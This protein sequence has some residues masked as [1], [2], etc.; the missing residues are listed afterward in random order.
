[1][2]TIRKSNTKSKSNT[3]KSKKRAPRASKSNGSVLGYLAAAAGGAA[4]GW[5]A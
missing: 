2:A 1:M 5:F 3:T 4:L